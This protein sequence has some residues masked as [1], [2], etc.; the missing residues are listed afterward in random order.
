MV[1]EFKDHP[2]PIALSAAVPLWI[3]EIEA[4]GGPTVED[5]ISSRAFA[6][7]LGER[8]DI[9]QFRGGK[10]GETAKLFSQAARAIA[11]LSFCPGGVTLFGEHWEAK[12][13]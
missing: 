9:L 4:C 3:M 1:T 6:E 2:L 10:P 11:I 7:T 5:L 8:G 12:A 13:K